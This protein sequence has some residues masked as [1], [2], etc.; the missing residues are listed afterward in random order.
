MNQ[1][2]RQKQLRLRHR[3]AKLPEAEHGDWRVPVEHPEEA[4]HFINPPMGMWKRMAVRVEYLQSV[5]P[6]EWSSDTFSHA[7]QENIRGWKRWLRLAFASVV[8]MPLSILMLFALLMQLYHEAPDAAK[9][10]NIGFWLSSPVWFSLMGLLT[11]AAITIAGVAARVWVYIYV[12]GHELTHA[13]AAKLSFGKIHDFRF[14]EEGGYVETDADNVFV[15][16]SPYFVPLWMLCWLA[17][18]WLTNF[19]YPFEAFAPW[20]Y[21]GFGFWGCFHIYWTV[22]IIPREQPDL[23]SN[24]IVFSTLVIMMMNVLILIGVLRA[25]DVL[26][27]SGY[28]KDFQQCTIDTYAALRDLLT[29]VRQIIHALRG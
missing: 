7:E 19:L 9:V 23:L 13:I 26:T 17:V 28:W 27:F 10:E 12:L 24:G 18:L 2:R 8:L 11:F 3:S 22:W 14:N 20:F 16:L 29:W 25:F 6:A 4:E 15:A 5:P 21:A 1:P